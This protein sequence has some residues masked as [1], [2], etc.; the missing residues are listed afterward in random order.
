L[1]ETLADK[2][3]RLLEDELADKNTIRKI[4]PDIYKMIT[5]HIKSI[6]PEISDKDKNLVSALSWAERQILH[7]VASR[8]IQL[9][10]SKFM[11]DPESDTT[12]LTLE[13]RYIVEPLLQ[14]KKRQ[15]RIEQAILNGQISQLE[16]ASNSVKQK[17]VIARFLQPYASITGTDLAAYGPF[18]PED[19]AILPIENAKHLAKIGIIAQNWVEP[20]E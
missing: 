5:S 3:N 10:I 8:L 9:R 20:M 12:N 14:S 16:Q 19:V 2:V 17:F 6:R 15:S 18:E 4:Q 11:R 7:D 1:I 13:E